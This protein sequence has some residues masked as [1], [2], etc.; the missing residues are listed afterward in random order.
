[1]NYMY[2]QPVKKKVVLRADGK[3]WSWVIDNKEYMLNSAIERLLV[4]YLYTGA[5]SSFHELLRANLPKKVNTVYSPE[6][7][8][9]SFAE[10]HPSES[11]KEYNS[12]L[13][14]L[15]ADPTDGMWLSGDGKSWSFWI[16][17]E[18]ERR[19][20]ETTKFTESAWSKSRLLLR[21]VAERYGLCFDDDNLDMILECFMEQHGLDPSQVKNKI[22]IENKGRQITETKDSYGVHHEMTDEER[23][24]YNEVREYASKEW[25][26]QKHYKPKKSK[27]PENN[28]GNNYGSSLDTIS[29]EGKHIICIVMA[30]VITVM[31]IIVF[32][33]ECTEFE[34]FAIVLPVLTGVTG[35]VA[36]SIPADEIKK[37]FAYPSYVVFFAAN[38]ITGFVAAASSFCDFWMN[39]GGFFVLGVS[40]IF[41][42]MMIRI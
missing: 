34:F 14:P 38:A 41:T 3:D 15:Y 24:K 37:N 12:D 5:Y 17:A 33:I 28:N 22:Y 7:L 40:V 30:I 29:T 31:W 18:D 20:L 36:T 25:A 11:L 13:I 6:F 21:E 2:I 8:K 10:Q 26:K 39:M 42:F 23:A 35:A 16:T 32:G 4:Y 27:Q 9:S 19:I 1:M